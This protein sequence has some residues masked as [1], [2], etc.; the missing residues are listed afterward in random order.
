MPRDANTVEYFNEIAWDVIHE[1][2]R[3]PMMDAFWMSLSRPDHRSLSDGDIT[4]SR[5]STLDSMM[6]G[7]NLAH[8]GPEVYSVLTR[9]W[10]MMIMETICP[11]NSE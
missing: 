3:F 9:K 1:K 2:F 7:D 4:R 11:A 10:V 8:A 6:L 5:H